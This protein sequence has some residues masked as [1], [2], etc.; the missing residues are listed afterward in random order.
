MDASRE[1]GA[2]WCRGARRRRTIPDYNGYVESYS[3]EQPFE[4]VVGDLDTGCELSVGYYQLTY[5][6]NTNPAKIAT[7]AARLEHGPDSW[8]EIEFANQHSLGC[9][10]AL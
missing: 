8:V 5:G 9:A 6:L 1:P 3:Q 7:I 4:V 2:P 10:K